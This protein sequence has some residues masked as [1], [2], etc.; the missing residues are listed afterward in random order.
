M[1]STKALSPQISILK[2]E[3][4]KHCLDKI[5]NDTLIASSNLFKK[6]VRDTFINIYNNQQVKQ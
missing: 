3:V 1:Y 4:L 6:P 2:D 5:T